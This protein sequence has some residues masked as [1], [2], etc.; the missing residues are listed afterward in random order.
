MVKITSKVKEGTCNEHVL[1]KLI[2]GEERI[3]PFGKMFIHDQFKI[4]Q[5]QLIC[6]LDPLFRNYVNLATPARCNHARI[7]RAYNAQ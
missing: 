3:K 5:L 7:S 2:S 4:W 1:V 6:I